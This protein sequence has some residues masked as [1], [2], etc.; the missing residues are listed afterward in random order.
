LPLELPTHTAP[1][2]PGELTEND[3]DAVNEITV[4]ARIRFL[5]ERIDQAEAFN[6]KGLEV[7][8]RAAS[9]ATDYGRLC[10]EMKA[11]LDIY[12]HK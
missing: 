9:L 3:G 7:V 8:R 5:E 6:K 4:L 11:E 1:P 2:L 12:T 10:R